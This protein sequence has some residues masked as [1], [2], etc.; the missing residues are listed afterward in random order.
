MTAL[1]KFDRA[2]QMLAEARQ[3]DEVMA[4]RD[5]ARAMREY[6]RIANDLQLEID[7]AT[8]RVYAERRLGEMLIAAKDAGQVSRGQP[9]KNCAP[10][11]QYSRVT[12]EEAGI[13]RKLSSK[14]Q[15][16]ASITQKAFDSMVSTMRSRMA[17]GGRV[18]FD[19]IVKE[20][21]MQK[22]R[23]AHEAK[24]YEGGTV[25]DLQKL[26]ASG[27]KFGAIY[28]DPAWKFES[29]GEDGQDRAA[30]NHYTLTTL[31][32]M[33]AMPVEAL[34]AD[35]CVLFMWV[36]D[37]ML[38][39]ALELIAAWGFTFKTVAFT[40]VK[41]SKTGETEHLGNGYWTRANP[42]MCLL[43]T[44][45]KPQRLNMDVRQL[46]VAPLQEH[47]R[48]PD[49]AYERI[50]RL[51]AGPYLEL[52]ARRPREHWMSWGNELPFVMPG[53]ALPY[54]TNT[55]EILDERFTI[56]SAVPVA[57]EPD[58]EAETPPLSEQRDDTAPA[59][60]ASVAGGEDIP[61]FLRRQA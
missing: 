21:D 14:A 52:F 57:D 35:D 33:K 7:A 9:K 28:A 20:T 26:E 3:V 2:R 43:A 58:E 15:K 34:A 48:K 23:R 5:R 42:E 53:E 30:A 46:L 32:D 17:E 49:E 44:R 47:S 10:E 16:R 27:Q 19:V 25:A 39:H 4:I 56:P 61:V 40:W 41:A 8:I 11:E 18:S 38:P 12:L 45:G 1:L 22:A 60:L 50:E 54:D 6:A 29:W 37:P 36:S 24:T 59:L 51:V 31:D 55:G 13:D